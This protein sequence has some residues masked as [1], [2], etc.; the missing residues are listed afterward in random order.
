MIKRLYTNYVENTFIELLI[1]FLSVIS[2]KITL[3]IPTQ[4]GSFAYLFSLSFLVLNKDIFSLDKELKINFIFLFIFLFIFCLFSINVFLSFKGLIDVF[5]AFLVFFI[6]IFLVK[7]LKN[8]N[9]K[10]IFLLLGTLV[11]IGNFGYFNELVDGF[12]GYSLNPNEASIEIFIVFIVSITFFSK[13]KLNYLIYFVLVVS[14]FILELKG[15]SRALLLGMFVSLVII[16][17]NIY[18]KRKL[19][20]FII[21]FVILSILFLIYL[22]EFNVKSFG[23]SARDILWHDILNYTIGNNF[24]FGSGFNTVKLII[25]E[26]HSITS[27]AHNTFI[28]IFVSSGI[29]GLCIFI[30]ILYRFIKYFWKLEY[31]K[32]YLFYVGLFGLISVSVNM[33]FDLKFASFPYLGFLFFCLG[34]IYSQRKIVR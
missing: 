7:K 29:I 13:N 32:T 10:T 23:L 22:E 12:Y 17:Y 24:F 18:G 20:F 31:E 11:L 2:L 9:Y 6:V 1:L 16:F 19:K 33:Q 5:K 25:Q 8:E 3:D 15:N 21:F 26:T 30:Y 4:I 27:T 14:F 28:E 34:L